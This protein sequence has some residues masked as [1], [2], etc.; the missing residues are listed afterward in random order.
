MGNCTERYSER[1]KVRHLSKQKSNN[2]KKFIC[3]SDDQNQ[4]PL[5]IQ[6][7]PNLKALIK[8][9]SHEKHKFESKYETLSE[10]TSDRSQCK[11]KLLIEVQKGLDLCKPS[12]ATR[13]KVMIRVDVSNQSTSF[14][15]ELVDYELPVWFHLFV[16][17]EEIDE[18][19]EIRF[20][21]YVDKMGKKIKKIGECSVQGQELINQKIFFKWI[22]LENTKMEGYEPK[23]LVKIQMIFDER[24][25][26][27]KLIEDVQEKIE[28]IQEF[29]D[30]K[31][32]KIE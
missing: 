20:N 24:L 10:S 1:D 3:Y 13:K 9:L 11:R 31:E 2:D 27:M 6:Y 23:I 32:K 29:I 18:K 12:C 14:E 15:T 16:I 22:D 4:L 25:L 7:L 21:A 8:E 28:K 26:F 5:Q 17:D 19:C 30:R